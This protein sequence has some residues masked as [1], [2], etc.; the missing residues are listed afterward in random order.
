MTVKHGDKYYNLQE[1]IKKEIDRFVEDGIIP[2][3]FVKSVIMNDLFGSCVNDNSFTRRGLYDTAMY[4]HENSPVE[5][6]GSEGKFYNWVEGG[7]LGRPYKD[8]QVKST[9]QV[10]KKEEE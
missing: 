1:H 6:R 10:Y 7:G 5:C 4:L 2:G 8:P 3:S 9:E